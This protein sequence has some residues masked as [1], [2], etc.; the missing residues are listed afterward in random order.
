VASSLFFEALPLAAGPSIL[1]YE[2]FYTC[3]PVYLS[4]CLP[5]YLSICLSVYLSICL[6]VYLYTSLPVCQFACLPDRPVIFHQDSCLS[7]NMLSAHLSV[8]LPVCLPTCTPVYLSTC[9]PAFI[10]ICQLSTFLPTFLCTWLPAC[11]SACLP[12]CMFTFLSVCLSVSSCLPLTALFAWLL[13]SAYFIKSVVCRCPFT[14]MYSISLC[15]KL[16]IFVILLLLND[17]LGWCMSF[18]FICL[19]YTYLSDKCMSVPS[20]L[21]YL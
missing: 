6:S 15:Y 1:L 7:V 8:C 9:V 14:N 20:G 12:V 19:Q 2:C 10:S 21:S 3:L 5:V 16:H 17:L 11:L 4:T 18:V 13:T